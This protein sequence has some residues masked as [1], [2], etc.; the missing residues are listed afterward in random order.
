MTDLFSLH[1]RTALVTGSRGG[2][3]RAIA[4]ALAGAGADLVLHGRTDDLDEVA[5]EVTKAGRQATRWI[6][7]LGRRVRRA[8]ARRTDGRRADGL[9]P[10]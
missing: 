6:L 3:G 4:M 9:D 5:E 8:P 10:G 7:D 2:I 1:G